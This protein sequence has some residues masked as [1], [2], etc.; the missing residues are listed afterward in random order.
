MPL[1][2]PPRKAKQRRGSQPKVGL[3]VGYR[4]LRP[5][6]NK[7]RAFAAAFVAPGG[8]YQGE[9]SFSDRTDPPHMLGWTLSCPCSSIGS[10]H[11]TA[12]LWWAGPRQG[13]ACGKGEIG[14]RW[15]L[16]PLTTSYGARRR[17]AFVGAS[18][19]RRAGGMRVH[20]AEL[21]AWGH[22]PSPLDGFTW[23]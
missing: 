8:H 12:W 13:R 18:S 14:F 1:G 20:Y 2:L 5:T 3:G 7:T 6:H 23:K 9:A 11:S 4:V 16:L 17:Q 10:R 22:S 15:L 19:W 21:T